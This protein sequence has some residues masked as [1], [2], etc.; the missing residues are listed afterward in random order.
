MSEPHAWD[1]VAARDEGSITA[2]RAGIL[3]GRASIVAATLVGLRVTFDHGE[4]WQPLGRGW[5]G[6]VESIAYLDSEHVLAGASTGLYRVHVASGQVNHQL[7][8]TVVSAIHAEDMSLIL[9]GTS[10]DGVLRSTDGGLSWSGANGGLLETA[11]VGLGGGGASLF[12]ATPGGVYRSRN[13]GR[14]WRSIAVPLDDEITAFEAVRGDDGIGRVWVG[15]TG[16]VLRSSDDGATWERLSLAPDEVVLCIAHQFAGS[17]VVLAVA[18]PSRLM[19]FD[20]SHPNPIAQHQLDGPTLGAVFCDSAESLLLGMAGR[21]VVGVEPYTGV[22]R[23]RSLG[24]R[25]SLTVSFDHV[26]DGLLLAG[27][28]SGVESLSGDEC[29]A[30]TVPSPTYDVV[31]VGGVAYAA[32][33]DGVYVSSQEERSWRR[34]ACGLAGPVVKVAANDALVGA[35]DAEC[36]VCVS[37][38][39][40]R[41][42]RTLEAPSLGQEPVALELGT[43][44]GCTVLLATAAVPSRSQVALESS[45]TRALTLW[46]ATADRAW[47]PL[48]RAEGPRS[49]AIAVRR[50]GEERSRIVVSLGSRVYQ[51]QPGRYSR[52]AAGRRLAFTSTDTGATIT[53][54][55]A[56]DHADTLVAATTVGVLRSDDGGATFRHLADSPDRLPILTMRRREA[57][58][59]A[60][61]LALTAGGGIWRLDID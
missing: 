27:V 41:T 38:D 43:D 25:A 6:P 5:A 61:L 16:Q 46:Q 7:S 34:V 49:A 60:G 20:D 23:T 18:T 33:A 24:L 28:E 15:S 22:T 44:A 1:L 30:S 52:T 17:R 47:E 35:V 12:A 37:R 29:S 36:R 39:R 45:P 51:Q 2:L 53:A 32:S 13:G 19:L 21:G 59:R 10:E 42:W 56:M 55:V 57:G 40:G 11:I 50:H 9:A 54:L 3:C 14:I 31:A 58:A 4:S 8:G 48:I 26:G